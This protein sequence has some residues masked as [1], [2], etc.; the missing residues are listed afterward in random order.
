VF[1]LLRL[2]ALAAHDLVIAFPGGHRTA[3]MMKQAKAAG[4]WVLTVE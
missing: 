2:D 1:L 4:L 3:N